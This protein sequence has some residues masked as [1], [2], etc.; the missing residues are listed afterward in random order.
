MRLKS[1]ETLRALM[2]QVGISTRRLADKVGLSH[3]MI[4]H[5]LHGRREV[6]TEDSARGIASALGAPLDLLWEK[7][8]HAGG[9]R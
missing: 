9:V 4:D 3:S 8:P 2:N 5:L 1:P 6:L 7:Y